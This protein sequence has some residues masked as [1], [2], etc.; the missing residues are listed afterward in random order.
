MISFEDRY[1]SIKAKDD[2]EKDVAGVPKYNHELDII[3]EV[4]AAIISKAQIS[5][6]LQYEHIE[7]DGKSYIAWQVGYGYDYDDA[8]FLVPDNRQLYE[9]KGIF[10]SAKVISTDHI[11]SLYDKERPLVLSLDH[12]SG[13]R[14]EIVDYARRNGVTIKDSWE[15]KPAKAKGLF[16]RIFG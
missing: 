1:S 11:T 15:D 6:P 8:I 2:A 4:I 12:I 3:K 9:G 16:L 7:I 14:R 5:L 13:R 10:S